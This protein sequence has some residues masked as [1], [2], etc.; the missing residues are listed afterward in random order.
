VQEKNNSPRFTHW[1]VQSYLDSACSAF[2]ADT[3]VSCGNRQ[4]TYK[5]LHARSNQL[6]HCLKNYGVNRQDRVLFCLQRSEQCILSIFGILKSD[7]IY[8]PIDSKSPRTRWQQIIEDCEPAAIICD[9]STIAS[10]SKIPPVQKSRVPLIS[11]QYSSEIAMD[12]KMPVVTREILADQTPQNPV[13]HNI[14]TDI[15]YILYTSGS[16]GQ[17][18]GSMISHLNIHNYIDWATGCFDIS[19]QDR[20]L[21]TA[22]FHFDMS[23][24]DIYCAVKSGAALCI[25]SETDMLFP[26]NHV[27]LIER[28]RITIWKAISS[29]IMYLAKTDAII[30]GRMAALHKILFGGEVLAAKYLIKWMKTYPEKEFYNVYGPTEATGIS[31]YHHVTEIPEDNGTPIPIGRPCSNTDVLLLNEK[32]QTAKMGEVG[33]LHMR[34]SCLS[35]GYWR[36]PAKTESA[37]IP[38]PLTKIPG[39]RIYRTRDLARMREDG[40]FEFLGRADDQ[41]KHLGYRIELQEIERALL[42]IESVHDA[43]AALLNSQWTDIPELTAFV[44][45]DNAHDPSDILSALKTVLP[46]YMIPKTIWP[47]GKIPRTSRGK[48]DRN[49]LKAELPLPRSPHN[50]GACPKP[51]ATAL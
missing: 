26:V 30:P 41:I 35:Q 38:N 44:E 36:D 19:K 42:S 12:L 50:T 32:N 13:Y 27:N 37:F 49:A 6:A 40:T 8:V 10:L 15:A 28:E 33:E 18:K 1:L 23:T 11:L 4:L 16:T 46:H 24:F 21:G 31:I 45:L 20:I 48:V 17:P 25:A 2:P 34:G 39:D 43:A 14:D 5:Q 47:V 51:C 3:A 29:L 22:P 9:N 7:A